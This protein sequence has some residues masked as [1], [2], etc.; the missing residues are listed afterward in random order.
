MLSETPAD[1]VPLVAGVV[2]MAAVIA[3]QYIVVEENRR[4]L[5][6]VA[7]RA[8]SD[9]LTGLPNRALFGDR[10]AHVMQQRERDRRNVSVLSL[11]FD[12]FK[13]VNDSLGQAAGDQLLV[14][15]AERLL[16]CVRTGDTVARLGG[17]EFAVLMEG[18]PDHAH[19]VADQVME[20]FDTPFVVEG[21]DL[22]LRPS[23]G[24]AVA[25][26]TEPDLTADELL[27]QADAAMST[28]KRSKTGGVHTFSVAMH[29][30]GGIESLRE[31][32]GSGAAAVRLLGQ[33]RHAIDNTDLQVHYQPKVDL[34]TEEVV[35][36]EALVR[37]QHPERGLLGPDQ[38]LP[39]V[40]EHG[41]MRAMTDLVLAIAL[42]D[43][44]D[45]RTKGLEIPVA[46]NLFAPSLAD[47]E[48]PNRIGRALAQRS[49]GPEAL[50]VE[51]TEDLLLNDI[52]RTR[53]VLDMLRAN[54]IRIAMDDF[55]SGY[56]ALW[57]LRELPIDEVKLDRE[58][59][60]SI[61]TDRRAAA[62]VRAVIDL[63]HVLGMSTV[64][65]GVED[66]DTV[67]RL[68]ELG[69]DVAQGYYYGPPAT[70]D[71]LVAALTTPD[72]LPAQE[73]GT[74]VSDIE[75]MQYR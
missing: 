55:G 61:V 36:V 75:L 56:S 11:D 71:A 1:T 10:L 9:P 39:L 23:V 19:L 49:L 15:A 32:G 68:R 37:W 69:C 18:G 28:A 41:L 66:V 73:A 25:P 27:S 62:I 57:Y 63:T 40:R 42:D 65:E 35:G 67:H 59:I 17:D 13:L 60:G 14:E 52:D 50:V 5:A 29:T 12:H 6:K 48:L 4:L 21:Y 44:A 24:L 33:L 51:I 43:V 72:P 2:L 34:F 3:R 30:A 70:A 64:A 26:P 45:W 38:F 53:T 22:L 7:D 16:R 74:S 54:G 8:L 31:P 46:V 47:L 58:F 20:A